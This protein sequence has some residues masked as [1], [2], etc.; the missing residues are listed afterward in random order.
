MER[1][2]EATVV[3]IPWEDVAG[4]QVDIK[5][6]WVTLFYQD[7]VQK[8]V[9]QNPLSVV[10]VETREARFLSLTNLDAATVER[11]CETL[12]YFAPNSCLAKVALYEWTLGRQIAVSVVS[13]PVI[14]LL[15]VLCFAF[16]KSVVP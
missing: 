9:T 1:Q 4:A 5:G 15:A 16:W 3:R 11:F 13:V 6:R 10:T 7:L 12:R 2:R 14:V 8:S